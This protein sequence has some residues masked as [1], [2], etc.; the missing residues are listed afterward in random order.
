MTLLRL[1]RRGPLS[2]D[3]YTSALDAW[4]Q[5]AQTVEELWGEYCAADCDM[6]RMLF[7]AYVG[8]L[9]AEELAANE[10]RD[11]NAGAPLPKAA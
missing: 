10:L 11:T 2:G 5:A 8:A 7:A 4:R 6:R 1:D 9:D 3:A